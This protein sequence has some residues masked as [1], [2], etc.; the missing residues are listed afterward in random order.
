VPSTSSRVSSASRSLACRR[1]SLASLSFTSR[2]S[3][4]KTVSPHERTVWLLYPFVRSLTA[5]ARVHSLGRCALGVRACVRAC[6]HRFF[7]RC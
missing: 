3:S 5:F 1:E 6:P 4:R 7:K 2:F